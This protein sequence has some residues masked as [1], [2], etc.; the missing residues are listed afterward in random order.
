MV[1]Q[2]SSGSIRVTD[3]ERSTA[4]YREVLGLTETACRRSADGSTAAA[5]LTERDAGDRLEL[6]WQRDGCTP[7]DLGESEGRLAVSTDDYEGA[8]AL[9]RRMNCICYED[10]RGSYYISDP[11]GYWLEILPRPA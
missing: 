8:R 9:H 1:F 7:Y 4:F 11:D 3:M 5:L 2:F 6:C 10:P